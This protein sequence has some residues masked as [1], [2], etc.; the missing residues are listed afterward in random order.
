MGGVVGRPGGVATVRDELT[1]LSDA[2][3]THDPAR[4]GYTAAAVPRCA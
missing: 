1:S 4:R 2:N 3:S